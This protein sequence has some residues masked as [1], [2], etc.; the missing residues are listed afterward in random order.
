[1]S[2]WRFKASGLLSTLLLLGAAQVAGN[3]TATAAPPELGAGAVV[4]L[5][6]ARLLDTRSGDGGTQLAAR[7]TLK[8]AV[9]GHGGVPTDGVAA[10]V[11]NVTALRSTAG[12]YVTAWAGGLSRPGTA[13]LNFSTGKAVGNLV[14]APVGADGTVNLY[15]GSDGTLELVADVSGYVRSGSASDPSAV[16]PLAPT[17]LLDT[18]SGHGGGQLTARATL[19]LK[20]G[21]LG[22]V[23]RGAAAAVL[24]VTALRSTAGGYVTAWAGG[25]TRPG[26]ASLNF[27]TGQAVG[28][29]VLVPLAADGTVNL[30]NGSSGTLELVA[31]VS[32]YVRSGTPADQGAV[33]P[34]APA[35]LL[36]TR[37]GQGGG[38]LAARATLNLVVAGHGG[39][40]S[41]GVA[42]VVLNVTALRST[43]GGY[44]TVWPGGLS[45]PG[46]ASLNFST[47]Q[48]VGNLVLA[49]VGANGSINLYNG[50][51]GTLQLVVDVS[52]YVLAGP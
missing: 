1:L 26:T 28:N 36:D 11:L 43:A 42:A 40:P 47:G 48:A 29:L 9:A 24:N 13:S 21:G 23:P 41:S 16:V 37:S 34:L 44:V 20:V 8:L 38:Q 2:R 25:A 33:V 3:S 27:S 12:G 6:P 52:G 22:G 45:R 30:Y 39:V 4:P 14:L 7:A 17:R 10:V 46:T 32:G 5:T 51:G 31:D 50:S 15:N 35:R 49:P 18:R 19:T